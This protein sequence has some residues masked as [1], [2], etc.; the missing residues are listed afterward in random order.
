MQRRLTDRY[1][2][3]L[4]YA[5][6]VHADQVRKGP[7]GIPY[8]SHLLSA[9]SL[10]LEAG[11]SEDEAIAALLHDAAEDQGGEPR[12]RDIEKHFGATVAGIVRECSDSLTEDPDAKEDWLVRKTRYLEHLKTATPS[13]LLVTAADK[14]H[15]ARSILTDLQLDGLE[16]LDNFTASEDQTLWYYEQV[17]AILSER[18][19][20]QRLVRTLE[21]TLQHI[22]DL[23]EIEALIFIGEFVHRTQY[24]RWGDNLMRFIFND[25]GMHEH[26]F[27]PRSGTWE[28]TNDLSRLYYKGDTQLDEISEEEAR[29]F[30]PEAFDM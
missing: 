29:A 6:E 13:A 19:V 16:Y 17:L 26:R 20:S 14:T 30:V 8:I 9:S 28:S 1:T 15:N 27:L 5:A 24:F 11:G 23:L 3:A 2:Q 25:E 22:K 12:L 10:V 7:Y 21:S 4:T 18:G